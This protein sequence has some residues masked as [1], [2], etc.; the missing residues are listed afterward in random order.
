[1]CTLVLAAGGLLAQR[2]YTP[3][4]IEQG[5][6]LFGQSCAGCHGPD[7]NQVPGSDLGRLKLRHATSDEQ[8]VQIIRQGI[9]GTAM[10]ANNLSDE[11]AGMIVGYLHSLAADPA[12][13]SLLE[14]DAAR[15]QA[16]F[17]G[18]GQ[19]QTCHRIKGSGG[20][21][22][23]D[24]SEIGSARRAAQ[25]ERSI[26]DPD[27]EIAPG[28]RPFRVVTKN[29]VTVNGK[30]LNLDTFTVQMLDTG[31]NLRS[32]VKS[33]LKEYDFVDKS[34]MPSYQGKL[35]SQQVADLVSYLA[36]LKAVAPTPLPR[37]AAR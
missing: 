29:G 26:L 7:G 32:F 5:G 19:C 30:L 9:P 15:G 25:L 16:L 33:D 28:N 24:L 35:S 37:A 18:A 21:L 1:M 20:R 11:Q 34:P 4:D 23:P 27:A 3:A 36:T 10:P 13:Q 8:I 17:T 6:R 31:E 12:R 2:Q 22:G 14:G